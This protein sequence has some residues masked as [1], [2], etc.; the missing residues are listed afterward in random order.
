MQL[1]SE[2]NLCAV[3]LQEQYVFIH[4]ALVEAILSGETEVAA[5]QLHRYVDELLIP[6]PAGRTR[7][8]KQFKVSSVY[9]LSYISASRWGRVCVIVILYNTRMT[10]CAMCAME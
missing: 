5:A 4:D 1:L 7:L 2:F 8:D 6:E 3:C 10:L 9:P